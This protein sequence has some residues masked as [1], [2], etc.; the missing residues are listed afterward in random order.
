MNYPLAANWTTVQDQIQTTIG[1]AI[2]GNP[3][4][5]LGAIQQTAVN[6]SS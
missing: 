2:T 4:K 6:G 3:A 5:I 1:Q